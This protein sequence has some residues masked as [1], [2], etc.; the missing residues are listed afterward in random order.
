MRYT[1]VFLGGPDE[2]MMATTDGE[3]EIKIPYWDG[4]Y[5]VYVKHGDPVGISPGHSQI[6][7]RFSRFWTRPEGTD[8]GATEETS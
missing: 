3:D 8:D 7:Y 4:S 6:A 5:A 1:A 2:G